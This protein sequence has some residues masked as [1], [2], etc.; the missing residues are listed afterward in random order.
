MGLWGEG[1][2]LPSH[3]TAGKGQRSAPAET[4][5]WAKGWEERWCHSSRSKHP[6]YSVA[7]SPP[8]PSLTGI[9]LSPKTHHTHITTPLAAWGDFSMRSL[10]GSTAKG[11]H[12]HLSSGHLTAPWHCGTEGPREFCSPLPGGRYGWSGMAETTGTPRDTRNSGI[13]VLY[14]N[15]L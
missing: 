13:Q 5:S 15:N 9:L 1:R 7:L 3:G 11:H 12:H 6:R 10:L 4:G 14:R 8:P 2:Q